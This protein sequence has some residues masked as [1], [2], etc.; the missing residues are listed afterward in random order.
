MSND[1]ENQEIDAEEI[2]WHDDEATQQD[3]ADAELEAKPYDNLTARVAHRRA[4]STL[5]PLGSMYIDNG[6]EG[7]FDDRQTIASSGIFSSDPSVVQ[8]EKIRKTQ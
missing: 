7:C 1:G 2:S 4:S 5:N 6:D 8:E 3:N